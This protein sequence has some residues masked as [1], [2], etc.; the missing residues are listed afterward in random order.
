MLMAC[1]A[2]WWRVFQMCFGWLRK[3]MVGSTRCHISKLCVCYPGHMNVQVLPCRQ[4]SYVE[5]SW[6]PSPLFMTSQRS[7]PPGVRLRCKAAIL[8][9]RYPREWMVDLILLKQARR[10]H[11]CCRPQ[12]PPYTG[13]CDR[14]ASQDCSTSSLAPSLS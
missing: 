11:F 13:L 2:R 8:Y 14:P 12:T 9:T 5:C 6:I 10:L 1:E 4:P 3:V 7:G